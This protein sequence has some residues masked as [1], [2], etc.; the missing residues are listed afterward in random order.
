MP[1]VCFIL[2]LDS[3]CPPASLAPGFSLSS[4]PLQLVTVHWVM[5][6]LWAGSMYPKGGLRCVLMESGARSVM[7]SGTTGM[8][9]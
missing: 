4:L 1:H 2:F 6:D 3:V 8:P 7:T 9:P 5:S